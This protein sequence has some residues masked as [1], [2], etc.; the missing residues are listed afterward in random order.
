MNKYLPLLC[1]C[2]ALLAGCSPKPN[3]GNA[4][5]TTVVERG[6]IVNSITSTGT[7]KPVNS[8]DVGTQVSG[9]IQKIISSNSLKPY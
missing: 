3:F 7:V 6:D 9:I 4:F 8:V 2:L 1:I 5:E